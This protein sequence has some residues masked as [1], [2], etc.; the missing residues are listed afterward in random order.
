MTIMF[1]ILAIFDRRDDAERWE[2]DEKEVAEY[3]LKLQFKANPA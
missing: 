1:A 3:V 2:K